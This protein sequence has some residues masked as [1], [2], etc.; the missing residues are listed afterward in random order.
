MGD[1]RELSGKG[2]D[3]FCKN[4]EE[5]LILTR[6]ASNN[7]SAGL[8]FVA[9]LMCLMCFGSFFAAGGVS[10]IGEVGSQTGGQA[11][12]EGSAIVIADMFYRVGRRWST[13]KWWTDATCI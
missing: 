12:T 8:F 7:S 6:K 1:S 9:I 4:E 11:A 5:K 3:S 13:T 10:G 2:R